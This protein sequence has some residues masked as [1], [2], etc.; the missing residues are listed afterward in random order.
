MIS[1]KDIFFEHADSLVGVYRDAVNKGSQV[2]TLSLKDYPET[3]L[4]EEEEEE[5]EGEE[6][7]GAGKREQSR[8]QRLQEQEEEGDEEEWDDFGYEKITGYD[9]FLT[10]LVAYLLDLTQFFFSVF[11]DNLIS[12]RQSICYYSMQ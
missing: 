8:D 5:E 7:E 3:L 4:E 11:H 10:Y 2:L 12:M 9:N 1:L 6:E